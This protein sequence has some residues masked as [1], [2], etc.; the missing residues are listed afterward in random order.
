M[1]ILFRI[2]H[3]YNQQKIIVVEKSFRIC[4]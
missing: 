1:N 3:S 4:I 2:P